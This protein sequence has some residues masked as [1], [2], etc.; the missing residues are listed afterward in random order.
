MG[1]RIET[2]V[3]SLASVEAEEK[4]KK[5]ATRTNAAR[6]TNMDKLKRRKEERDKQRREPL[7]VT[8]AS[9]VPVSKDFGWQKE[10]KKQK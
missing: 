10:K 5:A 2:V 7:L 8:A 4:E 9:E 1:G 6:Q 3:R